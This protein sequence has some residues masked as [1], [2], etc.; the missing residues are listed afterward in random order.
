MQST[1]EQAP[2]TTPVKTQETPPDMQ[3]PDEQTPETVSKPSTVTSN[4]VGLR[5][6]SLEANYMSLA[7]KLRYD[8]Y[9]STG[10]WMTREEAVLAANEQL[11][12]ATR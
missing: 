11:N 9:A 5:P 8:T 2:P 12:A 7:G 3:T 6:F 4:L 1:D 10:V